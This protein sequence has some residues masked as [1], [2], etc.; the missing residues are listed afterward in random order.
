[1]APSAAGAGALAEHLRALI[2]AAGPI[3]V[4]RFMAEALGHPEHGYYATRDPLGRAGDFTTAPE[5]SQVFG[6][7]IAAWCAVVWARMDAGAGAPSPVRLVELGPGRGTLIADILRT[8]AKVAP[9][10]DR[11]AELHLVETSPVL[12]AA[13]ARALGDRP[14]W[15]DALETVPDGPLILVANEFFD[16]L[17]IHQLVHTGGHWRERL[18]GADPATGALRFEVA[19]GPSPLA[20]ALPAGLPMPREG[21][22]VELRPAGD[23][24]M[25]ELARRIAR[26]GGAALIVDYGHAASAYGDTLQAVRGHDYAPVLADPGEADLT[27]HVDFAALARAARAESAA[28]YGPVA[29]GAFLAA[30]GIAARA[31]ALARVAAGPEQRA[32]VASGVARLVVP[33]AMGTLF[34]ALA[35]LHASQGPPPGFAAANAKESPKAS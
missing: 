8:L 16:A 7:L 31:E 10:L 32:A 29:Q 18:V 3:T 21:E 22:I 6:E 1:M 4:A 30:L 34:K 33:E 13:Q 5:I 23:A 24:V 26:H 20:A 12:R 9:D 19:P 17:P 28:V 15:H 11:A 2:A 14:H 35:V 27:A 25:A